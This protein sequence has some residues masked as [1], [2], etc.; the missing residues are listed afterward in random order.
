MVALMVLLQTVPPRRTQAE[1]RFDAKVMYYQE[2]DAR[3]EVLAPTVMYQTEL[4]PTLTIKVDGI[5]NAISG[6]S[7]TGAPPIPKTRTETRTI[8]VPATS[9]GSQDDGDSEDGGGDD[10]SRDSFA[11]TTSHIAYS[12]FSGATARVSTSSPSSSRT[13]TIE[14]PTGGIEIPVAEIE[15]TRIGASIGLTKR[16]N[17]HALTGLFSYSTENDYESFGAAFTHAIDFNLKNTTLLWGLALTHDIVDNFYEAKEESKDSIDAIIGLTQVLDAKTL[18]TVNLSLGYM[19]G[20]LND[21]YKVTELN[22][23][24]VPEQRPEDKSKQV[25]FASLARNIETLNG[26]LEAS[27]RFYN[28]TFGIAVNTVGLAWHQRMGTPLD[29]SAV[30]PVS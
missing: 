1:E 10:D 2:S 3:I 11:G 8:S 16:L 17:R 29:S 30:R 26:S 24:L 7:P 20:Y 27:Y 28:D 12:G 15:D 18:L 14:V 9:S 23:V 13:E 4:S 5:Y 21:P 22:G 6:A 25:V 19:T